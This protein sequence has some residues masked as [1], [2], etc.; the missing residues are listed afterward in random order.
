MLLL[1]A[2]TAGFDTADSGETGAPGVPRG[3]LQ[4]RWP[5]EERDLFTQT[6]GVDHD[7]AVYEE[8]S[9][10]AIIC[11]S[12]DGR[13]FPWCYDEHQGSDYLLDGGFDAMDAGSATIV[14]AAAGTVTATE[15]GHY[16]RCHA[17]VD[18]VDCDGNDGVANYVIVEHMDVSGAL[19][20]TR[21]WHMMSGSVSVAAGDAVAC[22]D[23]LGRVGSSGNSSQPHL[24]FQVEM[25]DETVVDPYAG[26]FSQPETFWV[27]QGDA[28]GLPADGC[29]EGA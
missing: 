12:Y 2:C 9:M 3:P 21:Y 22:G 28:E 4:F 15:D 20:T 7:P 25:A 13:A 17:T 5:L 14:A 19:W 27:E 6:V 23:V 10:E 1:F 16:D 11:T 29:A 24:H 26:E 8:A 18:G